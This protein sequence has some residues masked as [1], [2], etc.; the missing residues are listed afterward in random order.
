MRPNGFS[1]RSPYKG[2]PLQPVQPRTL[3][4]VHSGEGAEVGGERF[5]VEIGVVNVVAK[6][7]LDGPRGVAVPKLANRNVVPPRDVP[8][9]YGPTRAPA[10]G[11]RGDAFQPGLDAHQVE[12]VVAAGQVFQPIAGLEGYEAHGALVGGC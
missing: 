7:A 1:S 4:F 5:R 9:G 6:V 12:L 8:N 2:L 11:T 10:Q 3:L